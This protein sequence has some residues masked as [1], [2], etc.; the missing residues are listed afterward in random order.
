VPVSFHLHEL[1][2][3]ALCLEGFNGGKVDR[4]GGGIGGELCQQRFLPLQPVHLPETERDENGDADGGDQQ[5][6]PDAGVRFGSLMSGG[7]LRGL[8]SS[9][10]G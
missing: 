10:A 8:R 7:V 3:A 5:H 9:I 1:D 6:R 4:F 2:V